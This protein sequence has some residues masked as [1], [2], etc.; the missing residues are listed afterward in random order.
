MLYLPTVNIYH[1]TGL[2]TVN[3]LVAFSAYSQR[4][5]S[6]KSFQHGCA[7]LF[8]LYNSEKNKQL[9]QN[10]T[11][12]EENT[13]ITFLTEPFRFFLLSLLHQQRLKLQ[14]KTAAYF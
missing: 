14:L 3:T 5:T 13:L 2:R 8:S 9:K 10:P 4:V 1:L 12:H 7:I 6:Q 11:I